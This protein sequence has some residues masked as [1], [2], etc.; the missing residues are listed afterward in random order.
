MAV[1]GIG[2]FYE[3]TTDMT[4]HFLSN[5]VACVGY[6]RNV[7]PPLH[8]IMSHIKMGDIIYIKAHS[9][10]QGLIIKGVGIVTDA[11]I[12]SDPTL[13]QACLRVKWVWK[14]NELVG[15]ITD[16]YPVRDITLY[17]EFNPEVVKKVIELLV[18]RP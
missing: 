11:E 9:Q 17:E 5:G 16:G 8:K 3:N 1:F 12:F 10:T 18:S 4:S 6:M 15:H 14:G 7:A 13:G 2:A